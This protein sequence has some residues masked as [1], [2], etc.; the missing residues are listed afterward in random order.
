MGKN[1]IRVQYSGFIIFAAKFLSIFTGLTFQL[2]IARCVTS[3]EYG[4]WFNINDVL[5]YF[6]L[7]SSVLPFWAMRFAAR[8]ARGAIK[9][10]VL[11]NVVLSLISAVFYSVTVK[12]T[13]P[14]LGVGKYIS[15]Y[16]LATFLIIQYY[17][18]TALEEFSRARKPQALGYGLLISE[19]TRVIF[20]YITIIGYGEPLRGAVASTILAVAVQVVYYISIFKDELRERV[21]WGYIKEWIKGSVLNIYSIVGSQIANFVFIILFTY[22]GEKARGYYGAAAQIST[23]I[24]YSSFLAFA[25]Y[26]KLLSK[27]NDQDI[28]Q[29]LKTVLMFALPM[30][31]GALSMADS[32][33]AM[34]RSE[35]R[36]AQPVLTV[37]AFDA[38]IATMCNFLSF[39]LY[40]LER[41]DE[42]A[43][44]PF[45]KLIRSRI[46]MGFSLVYLQAAISLPLTF[47]ILTTY[48][49]AQPLQAA[50]LV[51]IINSSARFATFIILYLIVKRMISIKIPWE[52]VIKYAL[53][54][55]VMASV[56]YIMPK[57]ERIHQTLGLTALG[58]VMYVGI[59][60]MI[61]NECRKLIW[62]AWHEIKVKLGIIVS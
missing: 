55:A 54:S 27:R 5:L 16:M 35:Y 18:V 43:D 33:L 53:A 10:G 39:I 32:Y 23:V 15:I 31:F 50:L 3:E 26:P 21:E 40:G 8:G 58:G 14:M 47:Y 37:L 41:V 1:D 38:F 20:G 29:S 17:L 30:T 7:F 22:G 28:I 2:M 24:T 36:I 13:A 49:Q 19:L 6:V 45:L 12:L 59:T 61:D 11:A 48:C 25:L 9:T 52:N 46:F 62:N 42:K 44:I 51:A 4:V 34:L 60:Y 56:L 57:P